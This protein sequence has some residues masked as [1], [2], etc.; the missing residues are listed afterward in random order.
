MA[1]K[2]APSCPV[3]VKGVRMRWIAPVF[4]RGNTGASNIALRELAMGEERIQSLLHD[5]LC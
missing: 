5:I 2:L 3:R 1:G 4:I